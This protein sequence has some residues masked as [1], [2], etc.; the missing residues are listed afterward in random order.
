M[1]MRS[2]LLF[3]LFAFANFALAQTKKS[4]YSDSL[5]YSCVD[6]PFLSVSANAPDR[7]SFPN[8]EIQLTDEHGRHAGIGEYDSRIPNSRYG[9]TAQIPKVPERSKAVAV[10]VC[11][12][13]SGRYAFTVA[14]HDSVPYAISITGD[15]GRQT[16]DGNETET[17]NMQPHGARVCQFRFYFSMVGGK[18]SIEWVDK[19][20]RSLRFSERPDCDPVSRF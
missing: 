15:D 8:V 13:T 20:N 7:R 16:N 10:E 12:A 19:D 2:S 17:L 9:K 18:V 14:E 1:A 11:D 5:R 6:R 4:E 3:V